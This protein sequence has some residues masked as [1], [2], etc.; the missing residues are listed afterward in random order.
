MTFDGVTKCLVAGFQ[1]RCG[2]SCTRPADGA[3]SSHSWVRLASELQEKK[4]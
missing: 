3:H 1:H 2:S 4:V